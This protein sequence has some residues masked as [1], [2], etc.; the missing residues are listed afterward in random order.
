M[1]QAREAVGLGG[2]GWR[3]NSDTGLWGLIKNRAVTSDG[4]LWFL[5]LCPRILGLILSAERSLGVVDV[6]KEKETLPNL[7]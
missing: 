2:R 4:I 3:R 1:V 5:L 6:V 7:E